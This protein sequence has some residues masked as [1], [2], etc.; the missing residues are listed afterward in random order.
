MLTPCRDCNGTGEVLVNVGSGSRLESPPMEDCEECHGTGEIET[1]G[2]CEGEGSVDLGDARRWDP[3]VE[4]MVPC[5]E[6][7]PDD[8]QA[9][10]DDDG[11]G[12][13]Y[14]HD[15]W[16]FEQDHRPGRV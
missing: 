8:Y 9:T 16:L 2:T 1:C 12:E 6:C 14:D 4:R 13:E 3:A 11:Q 5:P 7:C 10:M 15:R